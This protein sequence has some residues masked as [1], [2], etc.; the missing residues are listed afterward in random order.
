MWMCRI[1]QIT[2]RISHRL[3][4]IIFIQLQQLEGHK[5]QGGPR[6]RASSLSP[7]PAHLR[8]SSVRAPARVQALG[9]RREQ[10]NGSRGR[11]KME[12]RVGERLLCVAALSS[13]LCVDSVLGKYVRGVVNTKEVS[14]LLLPAPPSPQQP[15]RRTD[16]P[17]CLTAHPGVSELRRQ[18][19]SQM[20]IAVSVTPTKTVFRRAC[21]SQAWR[22]FHPYIIVTSRGSIAVPAS[23][24]G[25][26]PS[27]LTREVDMIWSNSRALPVNWFN[28]LSQVRVICPR[29][30]S[31]RF[32]CFFGGGGWTL[33]DQL[34]V[35]DLI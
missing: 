33:G 9:E 15:S 8:C 35:W 13:L 2:K 27:P 4:C 22:M 14:L 17:T 18:L 7:F 10:T 26:D 19:V 24:Q 3:H 28:E 6:E 29:A 34:W 5:L 31:C 25:A 30:R 20:R 1:V 32:V 11:R 21:A 16:G 23:T 12:L